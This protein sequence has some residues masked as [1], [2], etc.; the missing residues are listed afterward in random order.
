MA[1]AR[2]VGDYELVNRAAR[3]LRVVPEAGWHAIERDV[4]AAVRTTPRGGWPLD[5]VDPETDGAPGVLRVSDLA[6][7]N[8]L[9]RALRDDPDYI[10]V[11]LRAESN[12]SVLQ[13]ISIEL[14][15]RYLA[16]A[17]AAAQRVRER[18]AAVV[19]DVIGTSA[20]VAIA[21]AV[22]DVHR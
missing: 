12:D 16:D 19:A 22:T 18:S 11:D 1:V 15:C 5:V 9:S 6:L 21:V 3:I 4:I 14:S 10:V 20:A 2:A 17:N 13:G 8:L 7:T